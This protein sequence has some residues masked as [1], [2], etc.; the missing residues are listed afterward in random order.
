MATECRS[1]FFFFFAL[2]GLGSAYVHITSF[3]YTQ[4]TIST[5]SFFLS[6]VL[7]PSKGH[8]DKIL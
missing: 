5:T 4:G 1:F 6:S 7:T 3:F 2:H 8:Q